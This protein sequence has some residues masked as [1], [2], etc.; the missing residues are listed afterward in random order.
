M[1]NAVIEMLE[2]YKCQSKDEYENALK[3]IMQ[4]IALLGLWRGKFFEHALFYGG[5]ALRIL[6]KLPRFSEDLDFS[7]LVSKPDFNLFPYY[8]AMKTE[9]ES[10]GFHVEVDPKKKK[11]ESQ[12]E[13][14]F[15]KASTKVHLMKVSAPIEISTKIQGNQLLKI[16]VEL[17]T[18]PPGEFSTEVRDLLTPIPFQVKTMPLHDLFAGKCHACLAREWKGR[19]KGRDFYDYIWYLGRK[20]PLNIQHLEA[21]L[22]QSGHWAAKEELTLEKVKTLFIKKFESLDIEKAKK[23]V[24]IFLDQREREGLQVW[25]KEF[26]LRTLDG[27]ISYK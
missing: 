27:L 22:V 5:T 23:D 18:D 1:D 16:K 11:Y 21:R 24:Y 9:L 12:V 19:V 14:A 4:E 26:F 8:Q 13:S 6:Y 17:D 3:E 20:I 7:L 2:S 25:S 10:F 15:I